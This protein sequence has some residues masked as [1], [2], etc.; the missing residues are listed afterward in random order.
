MFQQYTIG[1]CFTGTTNALTPRVAVEEGQS[2]CLTSTSM[3]M[4][5]QM[6][7]SE[8]PRAPRPTS[9]L[10]TMQEAQKKA[11]NLIHFIPQG[12]P[13]SDN[14]MFEDNNEVPEEEWEDNDFLEIN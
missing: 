5:A 11:D 13:Q 3:L 2:Q 7:C 10:T 6:E 14:F 4:H 1:F 8:S 9:P 12:N